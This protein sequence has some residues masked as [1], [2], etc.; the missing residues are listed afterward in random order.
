M[1]AMAPI[2]ICDASVCLKWFHEEGEEG[3]EASRQLLARRDAGQIELAALDLTA[4]EIGNALVRGR[5][6]PPDVVA[7]VLEALAEVVPL[8]KPTQEELGLAARLALQHGLTFYDSTY[9]A[10]ASIRGGRL[11]TFDRALLRAG[12]GVPAG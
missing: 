3:V 2:V 5:T 1:S 12:L 7:V 4:Y 8:V 6:L 11:V 9:A 10:V